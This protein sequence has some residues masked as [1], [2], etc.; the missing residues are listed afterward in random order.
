[1]GRRELPPEGPPEHVPVLLEAVLEWLR[2]RP[3]GVYVDATVG[4][5][6]H[7]ERILEA[8]GPTGR[9]VGIDRDPEALD[10]AH[11][12]LRRFAGRVQLVR[13]DFADLKALLVRT[14]VP[15]VDGVLFDLGVSGLQ[16]AHP[17]RGFSFQLEGPLDMRMDPQ[18]QLT[19]ADLVNRLSE[20]ELAS[21]LRRYGEEPFA[22]R[23]ARSIVRRRPLRTTSDL[24]AAVEAAVPPGRRP[25]RIH[26][27]T[28]TFQ[29]LRIA[30]NR[31]L[32]CLESALAQVPEVLRPGGRVVVI[33]FHSLEDRLVKRAFRSDPRLVPL[34][35]KPVR[36]GPEEVRRNPRARSARLRAAERVEATA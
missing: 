4:T 6:G 35:R 5:G 21:L 32:E 23:I 25:R 19:A 15:Q 30:T 13:G 31:E 34:V 11:R 22:G 29:A 2:P 27:A 9:L 8:C 28:R 20:R 33:S 17:E 14:G 10:V 18:Q 7:A 1:M 36:P 12:R 26:V 3:G 24:V 16:L